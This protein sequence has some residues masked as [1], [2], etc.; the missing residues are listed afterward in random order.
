LS[1]VKPPSDRLLS[2]KHEIQPG[3]AIMRLEEPRDAAQIRDLLEASFPGFGE[4]ILVDRLRSDGDLDLSLVAEDQGVV[5]GYVA[6]SRLMIEDGDHPFH[7]VALA[8]LAVYPEYQQQGVATRLVREGHACLAA[9]GA[10]LSVVVGEPGYYSRFG[11][12]NRRAAHFECE[13]QSPYLM[14]LSFGAAPWEG[15]LVYPTAF[16]LLS[17]D[18]AAKAHD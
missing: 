8:P 10:T 2:Q 3:L 1:W 16:R 12:S 17:E 14:A 18:A 11:Y 6:F 9:M 7:A 4:A 5:I 15:R 13:Y